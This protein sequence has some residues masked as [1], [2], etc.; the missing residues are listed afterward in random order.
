MNKRSKVLPE[1]WINDSICVLKC[2]CK[3]AE[4]RWKKDKLHRSFGISWDC[5][6]ESCESCKNSLISDIVSNNI[7]DTNWYEPQLFQ[8]LLSVMISQLLCWQNLYSSISTISRCRWS[9]GARLFSTSLSPYLLSWLSDVVCET[10][11]TDNLSDSIPS[12]PFKEAFDSVRSFVLLILLLTW[13]P[14]FFPTSGPSPNCPYMFDSGRADISV[15]L[16]LTTASDTVDQNTFLMRLCW[17]QRFCPHGAPVVLDWR[18]F[19]CPCGWILRKC[20]PSPSSLRFGPSII[21][22]TYA[23]PEFHPP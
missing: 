4:R 16:D 11:P 22:F 3:C 20:S 15:T 8:L 5:L 10:Q 2:S 13:T 9:S 19:L 12:L 21:F 14:L 23:A 18:E 17:Q 7:D 1:P 6:L